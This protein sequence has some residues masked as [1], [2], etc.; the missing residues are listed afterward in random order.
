MAFTSTLIG[1]LI[2]I[3]LPLSLFS[4]NITLF[5]LIFFGLLLGM[6][7]GLMMVL[8]NFSYFFEFILLIPLY[9]E[10]KFIRTMVRMN[11]I[12][13][14]IKNRRTVVIYALSLSFINFIYV[15]L[16]MQM[17]TSQIAELRLQG[18]ELTLS[19]K[20]DNSGSTMPLGK[21]FRVLEDSGVK[22]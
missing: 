1:L 15:T 8:M 3:F 12:A 14:R 11:L 10:R 5:V 17:E 22:N 4:E 6:L 16:L 21:F 20:G 19:Q 13:H 2:Y 9:M 18:S 7:I